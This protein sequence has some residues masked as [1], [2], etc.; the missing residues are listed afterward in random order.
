MKKYEVAVYYFPQWHPEPDA[1][2]K[3]QRDPNWTEWDVLKCA[4]PRF[5][6]HQQPKVPLWGYTDEAQPSV[7]EQK[8]DAAADHGVDVFL[9]DWYWADG[10]TILRRCLDEGYLGA[11]NNDRVK[12]ALMWCNHDLGSLGLGAV[13]IE[14][15]RAM[16]DEMIKDY[17]HLPQYWRV[18]GKPYFSIYQMFSFLETCG[19]DAECAKKELDLLRQKARDAGIGE[20]HINAVDYGVRQIPQKF[21]TTKEEKNTLLDYLGVDSV[22]SYVWIHH[23]II[24]NFPDYPYADYME[25]AL[26][27]EKEKS[28]YYDIPYHP[29]A[30]M[31]WDSSPRTDQSKPFAQ[32][33][34]PNSPVLVDNTP[35]LFREALIKLKAQLDAGMHKAPIITINSWNE[36]GEGSYIEPDTINGFGYLEAIRDVFGA[37]E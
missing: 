3:R 16:C 11:K 28:A 19:D 4:K 37:E 20:I 30:S 5:P 6:G 18:D 8:I 15:F 26:N 34:Y 7:M 36:W 13:K 2:N 29:H 17:F 22:T 21:C 27:V 9:F 25:T 31:G 1:A 12:F 24:P 32:G 23:T 33:V 14:T 10:G 35:E